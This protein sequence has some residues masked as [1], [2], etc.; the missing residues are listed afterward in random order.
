MEPNRTALVTG[1]ARRLGRHI[2]LRLVE[3]GWQVVVHSR[4]EADAQLAATEIGAMGYVV[5][6]LR[7]LDT[8]KGLVGSAV[9]I[10][11]GRL[12]LLVNNS[13]SFVRTRPSSTTLQD[14][15]AAFD[16]NARAP[17]FLSQAALP[18]LK[19]S[20]GS[21]CNIVDRAA[22][23]HWLEFAAHSAAKAA[24]SSLTIT[25]AKE[26][27]ELGVRVNGIS[28][29]T[30]LPPDSMS[31]EKLAAMASVPGQLGAPDDVTDALFS[32]IDDVTRTGEIVTLSSIS[33]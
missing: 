6:D 26:L 23:E 25:C 28:P 1:S 2:A 10:L 22:T 12:D 5:G 21:I 3:R 33:G 7:D 29:N 11:N 16:V 20:K 32:L 13:G 18:Y 14:W 27:Q 15:N 8:L 9:Q 17:L 24:L 19:A 30:V 4:S 31:V